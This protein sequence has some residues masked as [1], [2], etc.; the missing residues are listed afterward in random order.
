MLAA[1][2]TIAAA[3]NHPVSNTFAI[4]QPKTFAGT[5]TDQTGADIANESFELL[6]ERNKVINAVVTGPDGKYDFGILQPGRYRVRLK[7]KGERGK[8]DWEWCA[9]VVECSESSCR[10]LPVKV[11]HVGY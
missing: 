7:N 4:D 5:L 9:P 11:C 2:A 8:L 3:K 1:A 10:L 6:D